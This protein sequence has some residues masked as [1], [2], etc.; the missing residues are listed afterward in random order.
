MVGSMFANTACFG[1]NSGL[2]QES[3]VRSTITFADFPGDSQVQKAL[4]TTSKGANKST[5]NVKVSIDDSQRKS[6]L[7]L[8][9]VKIESDPITAEILLCP[10]V[11]EIG[12]MGVEVE[13]SVISYW[14]E[15][16]SLFVLVGCYPLDSDKKISLNELNA[17]N[18]I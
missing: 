12:R 18:V 13:N 14:S 2:P 15:L 9:N 17:Q 11:D 8:K 5:I 10:L 1:G 4:L 16:D 6:P 7:L 3:Q